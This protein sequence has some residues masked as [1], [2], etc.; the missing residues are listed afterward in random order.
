M[1]RP[2][3]ILRAINLE[4]RELEAVAASLRDL[5]EEGHL[6]PYPKIAVCGR[7]Y[8]GSPRSWS[9]GEFARARQWI[10]IRALSWPSRGRPADRALRLIRVD[11]V[12]RWAPA[13]AHRA[14]LHGLSVLDYLAN[15]NA[16]KRH[17]HVGSSADHLTRGASR[18]L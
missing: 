16:V 10:R 4:L 6:E 7:R 17:A 12:A 9:S 2:S 15:F 5:P 14:A 11:P 18:L 1:T 13:W 3:P 8:A